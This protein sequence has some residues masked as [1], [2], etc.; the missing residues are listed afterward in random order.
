M[1]SI[2]GSRRRAAAPES[3][4]RPAERPDQTP[5]GFRTDIQGL[6]AIAVGLV[7]L[8]HAGVPFVPG[9]YVGVDVFFVISGF[10]ISSHLM[11]SLQ[12]TGRIGFARFYARRALRILPASF[13]VAALTAIA[14]LLV[15]PPLTAERVLRDA[16]STILYVPNVWF[17]IQNTDYLA[18]HSP[19]PYQHY[20]S[21][22][23]EEQFYLFW[24]LVLLVIF[25]VA[26][27]HRGALLAAVAAVGAASLAFCLVLTP[28]QQPMAFFLLPTR[29]WELIAGALVGVLL[30]GRRPPIP[31]VA[32]ALGGWGG[33]ALIAASAAF[34]TDETPFPGG[35]A[36]L[37]V[38]G[39]AAV[40]FF[41][42]T[43]TR[44]SPTRLLSVRPMQFI[45]LI[46]YSLYL[47]HWPLLV[48]PQAV[49]GEADPLP[50]WATL[51]LGVVLAV[52]L[53]Y[54]LY[55]LIEN[56]LRAPAAL[57]RRRPRVT[58]WAT[59]AVTAILALAVA[60]AL[61]WTSTREVPTGGAA[62]AAPTFP[63]TTPPATGFLPSNLTPSLDA[64][65]DDIPALY[66]DGC[67]HDAATETVQSCLYGD[68]AARQIAVFGDSHSA[69]WFPAI[70]EYAARSGDLSIAAYTKSS[71]PAVDVPLLNRNVPYASCDRWR[72][73]V[74]EHLVA[75]PP[76]LVVISSYAHYPLDGVSGADARQV[77]WADGVESTVRALTA[78]G[79]RV[80]VIA[81]T[82]RFEAAPVAC[83]SAN[84]SAVDECAGVR[85][86]VLDESLASA[87]AEAAAA[88]GGAFLDL[89]PYLCDDERCP[90]ISYDLL[91]YRDVNHLTASYVRYLEPVLAESIDSALDL[92]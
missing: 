5:R 31:P 77:A 78:A 25:V 54:L 18:D 55:R 82:P 4:I 92:E 6:R 26:R 86:A 80:L 85:T 13:T 51:L 15:Y 48:V 28:V 33:L 30:L 44:L 62:D 46:S 90:V 71:C 58:L 16:L 49:V 65:A 43:P 23:I 8:Y 10:L 9:G 68:P 22:G 81:D 83:I 70:E 20:W 64:A 38:L 37:P 56:P 29:A 66:G 57:V 88:A 3:T 19:S 1:V 72:S 12:R 24:P 75:Q 2:D 36:T 42:A 17:A 60:S 50:L 63:S 73:A 41:G 67:H 74:L 89:T 69:Q 91:V 53:A 21:L 84:P 76:A 59:L 45:G 79:S 32:A 61:A 34:F 52:P 40:I 39:T 7:L 14:V 35:A 47:V 11:E 27:R 87:E